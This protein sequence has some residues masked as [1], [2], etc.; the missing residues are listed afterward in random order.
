[1]SE[2]VIRIARMVLLVLAVFGLSSFARAQVPANET[3][4]FHGLTFP[5]TIAGAERF[6][7]LDYEKDSPGLGYGVGYRQPGVVTTVYIYDLKKRD[8]PDDP[9]APAIATQL[10]AGKADMLRAPRQGANLTIE[11]KDQFSIADVHSR[12]RLVCIA[13]KLVRTDPPNE[14]VSHLCVGGWKSK[15]VKFRITTE[16]QSQ[17][18][19]RRLM[20]AWMDL[21][22]PS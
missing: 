11:P 3:V 4:T 7:V 13:A 12:T 15:F 20:Q 8:I 17:A 16:Q 2:T 14:L 5:S 18:D 21:L 22:W 6:S 1:M 9:S 19:A 10:E